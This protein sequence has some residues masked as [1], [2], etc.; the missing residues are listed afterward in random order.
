MN[1]VELIRNGQLFINK[2]TGL[3]ENKISEYKVITDASTFTMSREQVEL[4]YRN[5]VHDGYDLSVKDISS[6]FSLF[7]SSD[8]ARIRMAFSNTFGLRKEDTIITPHEIEEHNLDELKEIVADFVRHK[9]IL[10]FKNDLPDILNKIIDEQKEEIAN[11][12]DYKAIIEEGFKDVPFDTP[13][14][15]T[16]PSSKSLAIWLSDMHI[17]CKVTSTGAI[18]Q[19][20]VGWDN[21]MVIDRLNKLL[22]TIKQQGPFNEIWVFNLGDAIDGMDHTTS[23][24]DV[25]L[26]QN[27]SNAEMAKYYRQ[28]INYLFDTMIA[29]HMAN[30]YHFRTVSQSNH[31]GDFEA[32]ASEFLVE[33]LKHKGIDSAMA[34]QAFG[35]TQIQNTPI[36]YGHGKDS[37][38]QIRPL[39]VQLDNR[40]KAYVDSL[41]RAN[42][43]ASYFGNILVVK[44][45]SHQ[46]HL[47]GC[48]DYMYM[49]VGSLFGSSEW[50]Q[51]NFPCR[52]WEVNYSIFDNGN[53]MHGSVR[54]NKPYNVDIQFT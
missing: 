31:G 7:S 1:T 46:Y 49:S 5:Y 35:I 13:I 45:D 30:S 37:V 12:K 4:L 17:G 39:G 27:M 29:N 26:P 18:M 33:Q 42:G 25:S 8:L 20:N 53:I 52:G 14:I 54:D 23:R 47:S 24:R 15:Q 10:G 11:L 3:E 21:Q 44:G 2:L 32:Q 28:D 48:A 6:Y 43:L 51:S 16:I 41:L 34:D 22:L 19:E 9:Q 50:A 36:V 38:H 40:T